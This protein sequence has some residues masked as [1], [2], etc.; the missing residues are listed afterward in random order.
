[1]GFVLRRAAFTIAGAGKN[2]VAEVIDAHLETVSMLF[3]TTLWAIGYGWVEGTVGIGHLLAVTAGVHWFGRFSTYHFVLS[4]TVFAISFSFGFLKFTRMLF[5]RKRYMLFTALGNYP[6]ALVAQDFAY[7]FFLPANEP[8]NRLTAEAWTC[9]GLGLGC[10]T[11]KNPWQVGEYATIVLPYWYLVA[12]AMSFCFLFLAYRSALVNLLVTRQ[13]VKQ[14]GFLEK[15]R[16]EASADPDRKETQELTPSPAPQPSAPPK[17]EQHVTEEVT[18]IVDQDREELI[19]KLRE[20]LER[21][22]A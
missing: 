9:Q 17:Q 16:M 11:L 13:V 21:Q 14:A 15:T 22:G 4:L 5:Y 3:I 20:R 7:F 8:L 1:L 2:A 6:Y 19:R 18:R 10:A 12:L